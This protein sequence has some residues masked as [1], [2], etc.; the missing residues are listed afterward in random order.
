MATIDKRIADAIAA[1]E[2]ADDRPTR[3][4]K[5]TNAWGGE[6]FGVTFEGQDIDKYVTPT[7]FIRNPT[8]YWEAA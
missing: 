5:Y 4:V 3:I 6:A 8:I 1:G 2:Y 7:E